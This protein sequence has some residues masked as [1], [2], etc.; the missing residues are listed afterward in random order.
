MTEIILFFGCVFIALNAW[1]ITI[2]KRIIKLLEVRLSNV[3]LNQ[4][5]YHH[6]ERDDLVEKV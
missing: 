5:K 6:D 1:R 3:E 2:L 4:L